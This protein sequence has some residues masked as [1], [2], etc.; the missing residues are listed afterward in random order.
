MGIYLLKVATF[1]GKNE[2]KFILRNCFLLPMLELFKDTH[3]RASEKQ[4]EQNPG[5]IVATSEIDFKKFEICCQKICSQLPRQEFSEI[6]NVPPETKKK[7]KKQDKQDGEQTKPMSKEQTLNKFIELFIIYI[8]NT[9]NT[10]GVS[11]KQ[12]EKANFIVYI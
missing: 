8:C 1:I 6:L 2:F 12:Q 9:K 5:N 11:I 10:H 3:L 4:A 7:G